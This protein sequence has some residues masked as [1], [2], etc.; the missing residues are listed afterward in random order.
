MEKEIFGGKT[1]IFMKVNSNLISGMGLEFTSTK[2]EIHSKVILKM[3]KDTAK[4]AFIFQM[5]KCKYLYFINFYLI[6]SHEKVLKE[7]T[8]MVIL[9]KAD[10]N[11]ISGMGLESIPTKME[12]HSKVILKII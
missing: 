12:I 4:E 1:E 2:M 3:V 7:I 6:Y 8:K 5:K 11:P 10:S 9:I